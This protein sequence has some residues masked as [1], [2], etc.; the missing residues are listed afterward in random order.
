[1]RYDFQCDSCGHAEEYVCPMGEVPAELDC[2]CGGTATQRFNAN[3]QVLVKGR[4]FDFDKKHMTFP[5]NWENG[6]TDA[7]AQERAYTKRIERSRVLAQRVERLPSRRKPGV[8]MIGEIP[9]E[10]HVARRNQYGPEYWTENPR[11][12]L[13]RD[14]LLFT[15]KK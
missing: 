5:L 10:L 14:G 6:N 7:A 13:A 1:M 8:R 9:L 2:P 12:A 11:E 15:K 4:Q 3:V